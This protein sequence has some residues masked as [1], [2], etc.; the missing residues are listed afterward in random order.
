MLQSAGGHSNIAMINL[1]VCVL[2]QWQET[3]K[4]EILQ[5]NILPL[6]FW[7]IYFEIHNSMKTL[8][9]LSNGVRQNKLTKFFLN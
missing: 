5:D 8:I 2:M 4:E 6:L 1:V 7:F 9:N 3:E